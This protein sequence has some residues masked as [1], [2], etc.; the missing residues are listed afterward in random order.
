MGR[1]A[2]ERAIKLDKRDG[3]AYVLMKNIYAVVS[4]GQKLKDIKA[5]R[6]RDQVRKTPGHSVWIG[7]SNI[8]H[9]ILVGTPLE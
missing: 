2:F 4:M 9:E 1:W 8:I 7:S 6:I 5:M 3:P